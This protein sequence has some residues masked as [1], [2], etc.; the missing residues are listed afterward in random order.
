MGRKSRLFE[1]E[2]FHCRQLA[3]EVCLLTYTLMQGER[4]TRRATIWKRSPE[5]WKIIFHQGTIVQDEV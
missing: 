1:S 4:K 3:E 5:G 2:S